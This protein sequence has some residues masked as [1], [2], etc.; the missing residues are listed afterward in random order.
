[1][2]SETSWLYP[3]GRQDV[4]VGAEARLEQIE[5]SAGEVM[6]LTG[7]DFHFNKQRKR[8]MELYKIELPGAIF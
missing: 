6:E 5:G 2:W 1:M 3:G 7:L 8:A 4:G